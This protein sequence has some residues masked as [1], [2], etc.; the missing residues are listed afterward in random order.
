MA[1]DPFEEQFD[2]PPAPVEF[3]HGPR[4]QFKLIGQKDQG[5]AGDFIPH[6][7]PAQRPGKDRAGSPALQPNGL[8]A[9]QAGALVHRA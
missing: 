4:G 9:T 2:L 1:F 5:A 7:H 8:V 6:P 3:G